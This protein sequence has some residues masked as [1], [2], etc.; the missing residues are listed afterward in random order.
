MLLKRNIATEIGMR[1]LTQEV[2]TNMTGGSVAVVG[3]NSTGEFNI[4]NN[5]I[6]YFRHY[7]DGQFP[8]LLQVN[9]KNLFD[10]KSVTI[11][12]FKYYSDGI[13]QANSAYCYS[14]LISCIPST[15]YRLSYYNGVTQ[16]AESGAHIC[17][18]DINK[19]YISG[20]STG[21]VNGFTTPSNCYFIVVSIPII[22]KSNGAML[23]KGTAITPFLNHA[24][25]ISTTDYIPNYALIRNSLNQYET[26]KK[27]YE[28]KVIIEQKNN[29][30]LANTN[31]LTSDY[32][33]NLDNRGI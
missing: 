11:G 32:A 12:G 17:Y 20:I 5:S 1:D 16:I 27:L 23:E 10:Y 15:G 8:I 29:I 25:N 13:V 18:Y 3:I 24:N 9:P 2:K 7:K 26:L 28:N 31:T 4:K 6:E 21:S 30:A 19:V 22:S 14:P 33:L